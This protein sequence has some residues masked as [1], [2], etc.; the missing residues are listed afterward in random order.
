MFIPSLEWFHE[1]QTLLSNSMNTQMPPI[2]LILHIHKVVVILVSP[3]WACRF[4]RPK[5]RK[6]SCEA[7]LSFTFHCNEPPN[8]IGFTSWISFQFSRFLH[9]HYQPPWSSSQ[10]PPAQMRASASCPWVSTTTLAPLW[11][12]RYKVSF[13][14]M[15]NWFFWN[16]K[17]V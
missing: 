2:N 16:A 10:S 12:I 8:S 9:L 11:S 13:F 14:G 5:I 6:S 17:L 1:Y 15:Q 4:F 7:S 3:K